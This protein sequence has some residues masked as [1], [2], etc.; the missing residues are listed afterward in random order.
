MQFTYGFDGVQRCNYFG[1]EPIRRTEVVV[2]V[3]KFKNRNTAIKDEVTGEM[4]KGGGDM[5]ADWIW[6][7]CSMAFAA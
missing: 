1:R 4:V 6:R 3:R 2:R 5:V 7:V